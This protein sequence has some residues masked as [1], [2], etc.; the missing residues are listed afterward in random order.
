[1]NEAGSSAKKGLVGIEDKKTETKRIVIFMAICFGFAWL[2]EITTIIPMYRTG[3]LETIVEA[4]NMITQ[5]MLTP[6]V[7]ALLARLATREGLYKSGFQ[8]NFYEHRFIFLSGWFGM[9][10]L[11]V[12]GAVI[13][14]IIFRDNF[15]PDMT[16]FV[17]SYKGN[18][19]DA[20]EIMAAFKTDLLMKLF[21]APLLDIVSAFGIEWGFRA[22]LLPKLYRKLGALPSILI[23]ST[24]GGLWLAPLTLIGYY[25]GEG[26]AGFPFTGI[27]AICIFGLVTGVIY[28][29]MA[30]YTGSIL[31]SVFAHS[32]LNVM[33]PAAAA[34]TFD[35]GNF[36][37][38][39]APTGILSG[40]PFIITAVILLVYCVK[41]PLQ[42][43]GDEVNEQR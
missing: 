23:S 31:P 25:Y 1:M 32:A 7:A 5:L 34:F 29:F 9:T 18:E 6:A 10:L 12:T 22:Y 27:L 33:M 43:N 3:E 8:F 19:K 41:H 39:P 36:F 4:N 24:L 15:D 40:I 16:A 37:V 17:N 38:G 13:Y 42:T 26:Y 28:S 11:T 2:V 20:A 30:L 14:F 35:G 21:S